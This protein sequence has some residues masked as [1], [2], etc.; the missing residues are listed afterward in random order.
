[1]NKITLSPKSNITEYACLDTKITAHVM[2]F[3]QD[4][5]S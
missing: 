3:V 1:M 5:I 4:P 2:Q